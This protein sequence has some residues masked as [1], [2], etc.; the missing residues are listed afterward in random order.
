M[1]IGDIIGS[2]K[3][4]PEKDGAKDKKER[5]E[6]IVKELVPEPPQEAPKPR[7]RP[8][9]NSTEKPATPKTPPR[10]QPVEDIPFMPAPLTAE[11]VADKI[12]NTAAIRRLRVY[13]RRFPQ[14]SP[15][16]QE[17]NPHVHT[18]R[19]NNLV[20][21]SIKEAVKAEVEF[22]TAPSLISDGI[23]NT[24]GMAMAWAVTNPGHPAAPH[25]M[26]LH[27]AAK[28]V[29]SDPAVDLDIGLMECEIHGFMPDSAIARLLLN[30]ARVL[31]NVWTEN[32]VNSVIPPQTKHE[33]GDKY[34]DF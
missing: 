14:F 4:T 28:A 32:K 30:V 20:I 15:T 6:E 11:Q 29:L 2:H 19:E 3:P 24:E 21:D 16:P 26:N 33:N 12:S 8:R 34:K 9:K 18:A 27:T 5:V 7:G 25:L 1:G 31:G 10:Q 13:M 23:R 17:Y 22:L